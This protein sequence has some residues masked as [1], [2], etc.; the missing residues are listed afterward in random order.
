MSAIAAGTHTAEEADTAG[1]E[2]KT[3]EVGGDKS[4]RRDRRHGR[5]AEALGVEGTGFICFN[6][7][8]PGC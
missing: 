8:S 5:A 2:R 7:R 4:V 6:E 1:A 3:R